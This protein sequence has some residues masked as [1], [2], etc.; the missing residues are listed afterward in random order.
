MVS[1]FECPCALCEGR[2]PEWMDWPDAAVA[3][4]IIREGG[5]FVAL[6]PSGS[7]IGTYLSYDEALRAATA[8]HH[9]AMR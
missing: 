4:L 9:E 7:A 8:S 1:E 3:P 6:A 5:A 2:D